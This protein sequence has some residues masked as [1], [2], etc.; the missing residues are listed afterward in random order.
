MWH[1]NR[2]LHER[3]WEGVGGNVN[4]FHDLRNSWIRAFVEEINPKLELVIY[5]NG[6][7]AIIR[8]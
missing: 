3:F 5:E 1:M 8:K 2:D 7:K 4:N 6:D